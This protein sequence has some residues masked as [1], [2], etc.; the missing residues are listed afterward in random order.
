MH[1][2]AQAINQVATLLD[3]FSNNKGHV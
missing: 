2:E 1:A 3:P